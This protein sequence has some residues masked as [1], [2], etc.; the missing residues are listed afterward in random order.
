MHLIPTEEEDLVSRLKAPK[1]KDAAF[2]EL[3]GLYKRPLYGMLR[4]LMVNHEDT[5]EVL[6]LTFIKIYRYIDGFKGDSKLYTWM[7]TIARNE[8]YRL[9]KQ[10]ADKANVRIDDLGAQHMQELEANSTYYSGD[11]IQYKLQ[12]AVNQLPLKQREVF[13]LKYFDGLKYTEIATITG[14]TV[15]G[16]KA[17]YHLAVKRI[18]ELLSID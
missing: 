14:I 2:R 8:A 1:T 9:L 11:E 15:G 7:Y 17:N 5:D 13:N 10:K 3:M 18:K 4:K 12:Q 6:Q 16:L